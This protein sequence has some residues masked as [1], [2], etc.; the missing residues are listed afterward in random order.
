MAC[1][2][3]G[4]NGA[5]TTSRDRCDRSSWLFLGIP[6]TINQ[7]WYN[8]YLNLEICA[9]IGPRFHFPSRFAS[10]SQKSLKQYCSEATNLAIS[11]VVSSYS[12]IKFIFYSEQEHDVR[13]FPR[14]CSRL[15]N[16]C[17]YHIFLLYILHLCWP[18]CKAKLLTTFFLSPKNHIVFPT[19][20]LSAVSPLKLITCCS[21][22]HLLLSRTNRTWLSV[23]WH[24]FNCHRPRPSLRFAILAQEVSFSQH[25][26]VFSSLFSNCAHSHYDQTD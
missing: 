18:S 19:S 1:S 4:K 21:S 13:R 9:V 25:P 10:F 5:R 16:L 20:T 17:F 2:C 22:S 3:E 26:C 23:L 14:A 11:W 12:S 6:V 24:D 8:L 15:H 7:S